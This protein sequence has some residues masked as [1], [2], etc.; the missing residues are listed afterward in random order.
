MEWNKKQIAESQS[1]TNRWYFSQKYPH[2]KQP[3]DSQLLRYYIRNGGAKDFS[4]NHTN[5][6]PAR[7]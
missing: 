6:K 5:E 3:S 7:H 1:A 2:I 4:K